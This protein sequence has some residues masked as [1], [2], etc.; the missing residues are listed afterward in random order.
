MYRTKQIMSKVHECGENAVHF[1]A[2]SARGPL[3]I[4]KKCLGDNFKSQ[5]SI[6]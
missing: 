1:F 3:S 5:E 2:W 4:W 6:P